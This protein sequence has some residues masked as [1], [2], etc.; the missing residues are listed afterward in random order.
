M[1]Q[2]LLYKALTKGWEAIKADPTIIDDLFANNF[3]LDQDEV[4]AIKTFLAAKPPTIVHGYARTDQAP[5]LISILLT[6]ERE[7]DSVL[8][9]EAGDVTTLDDPDFGSSQYAAFWECN[10]SLV[11]MA[12]H[13]D[14]CQYIYELSKSIIMAAKPT[15]IPYGVYGM[16]VSGS[17]LSPDPRYMPEHFFVRQL[18]ISC[19]AELLTVDKESKLGKV[20]KVGGIHVDNSSS[21]EEIGGVKA[22]I[23]VV[24]ETDN[25][26]EA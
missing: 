16:Q 11:H 17:D 3:E 19:R 14:V 22:L 8:G 4:N 6:G 13:P 25:G 21:N 15:F 7:A 26:E 1:I 2:R 12:E 24:T 5:P 20:Y 10:Y 23:T 18:T 9:D